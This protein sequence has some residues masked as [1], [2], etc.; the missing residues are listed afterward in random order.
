MKFSEVQ[1]HKAK[2]VGPGAYEYR[3]YCIEHSDEINGRK[4]YWRVLDPDGGQIF[5]RVT[6]VFYAS[7]LID[8]HLWNELRRAD[9]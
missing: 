4:P 7:K 2:R 3:D 5:N 9:S 6:S 1:T 8:R